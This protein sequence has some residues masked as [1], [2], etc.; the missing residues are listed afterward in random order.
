MTKL[1]V[2]VPF[3]EKHEAWWK[4]WDELRIQLSSDDEVII[5]D[6]HSPSGPPV[7]DCPL[8]K[9]V[10]PNKLKEHIYRCNSLRNL[11]IKTAKHDANNPRPRLHPSPR[12]HSNR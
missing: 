6:D 10:H 3:F 8:V 1:S 2:V 4:T 11:G 12:L 5:V 7:C 9:I